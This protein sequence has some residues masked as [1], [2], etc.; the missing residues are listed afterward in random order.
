LF[1]FVAFIGATFGVWFWD[2][3][4][5]VVV[6]EA[7]ADPDI[8]APGSDLTIRYKLDRSKICA[9]RVDR[10]IVDAM[11]VRYSLEAVEFSNVTQPLGRNDFSVKI[12]LPSTMAQGR[13]E[14]R[15]A[16]TFYCNPWQQYF[17]PIRPPS[18]TIGFDVRGSAPPASL[19]IPIP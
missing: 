11:K 8:A 16:S 19:V 5:P 13:A 12:K 1:S 6:L 15:A 2:D 17:R 3:A 4:A 7:R 18:Y 9:G 14:Y 10:T